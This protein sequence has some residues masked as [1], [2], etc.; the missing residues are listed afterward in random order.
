MESATLGR[1]MAKNKAKDTA[2]KINAEVAR[3][4][5]IVASYEGKSLSKYLSDVLGPI[6]ERD[7][8]KYA[9]RAIGNDSQPDR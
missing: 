8:K 7:H 4:A 9:K 3:I 6:V 1:T 2:V 5:R